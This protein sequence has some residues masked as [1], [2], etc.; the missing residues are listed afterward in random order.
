LKIE[1]ASADGQTIQVVVAVRSGVQDQNGKI[2]DKK[3]EGKNYDH[4]F[5]LLAGL[6]SGVAKKKKKNASVLGYRF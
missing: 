5:L 1:F 4:I 6:R 2:R 3:Q